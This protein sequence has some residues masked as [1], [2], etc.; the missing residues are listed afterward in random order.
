[1]SSGRFGLPYCQRTSARNTA[2]LEDELRLCE[3]KKSRQLPEPRSVLESA[4][5]LAT[6]SGYKALEKDPARYR[7]SP[8]H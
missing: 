7:G 6:R 8:K 1:M 2:G 4:P 3:N 5:I